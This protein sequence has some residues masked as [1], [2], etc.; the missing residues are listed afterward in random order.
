VAQSLT[1]LLDTN[2][3]LERLLDQDRADEVRRLLDEVSSD[4]LFITDFSFHSIGV[5]L[6][7]LG[8]PEAFL[9]FAEDLFADGA[10]RILALDPA[11]MERIVA[12]ASEYH[13]D[14]DDAYQCV[15]A[16][17]DD[18]PLVS[19]DEDFDGTERGR[20]TPS[21]VLETLLGQENKE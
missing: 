18:V 20:I 14:F 3:W 17:Q 10:V 6:P 1:Y 11:H 13:L 21:E 12:V 7:R 4:R 9:R 19:F 8:H 2:I 5:I 15:A 16:E